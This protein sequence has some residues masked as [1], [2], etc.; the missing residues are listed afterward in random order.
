MYF[1]CCKEIDNFPITQLHG[2]NL[3]SNV[4]KTG[5]TGVNTWEQGVENDFCK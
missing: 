3:Y 2:Y 5:F 1:T 4:M